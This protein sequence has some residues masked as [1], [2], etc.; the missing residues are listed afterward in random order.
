L[1]GR[2]SAR[3]LGLHKIVA[4]HSIAVTFTHVSISPNNSSGESKQSP[5]VPEAQRVAGC[6]LSSLLSQ[7]N[8]VGSSDCWGIT[9][10]NSL[11]G[12]G[13]QRSILSAP[14]NRPLTRLF[15]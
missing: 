5:T 3:F 8:D 6:A 2:A 11:W 9:W 1:F 15:E 14:A 7:R 13:R 4:I 10:G 12:I